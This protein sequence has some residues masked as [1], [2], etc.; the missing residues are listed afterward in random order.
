VRNYIV[1][2]AKQTICIILSV[3]SW[4]VSLATSDNWFLKPSR[5]SSPGSSLTEKCTL[6]VLEEER[7]LQSSSVSSQ[8]RLE[9]SISVLG[10]E[11][12]IDCPDHQMRL[13]KM[14]NISLLKLCVSENT[15]WRKNYKDKEEL[16]YLKYM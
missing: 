3:Q 13:S 6:S 14:L 4:R 10:V 11:K 2:A 7:S 9:S 12:T 1:L 16:V 15:T 5:S 8:Q